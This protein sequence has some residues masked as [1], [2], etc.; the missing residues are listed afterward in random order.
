MRR[1][2]ICLCLGFAVIFAPI[3]SEAD[4]VTLP[5]K[6]VVLSSSGLAQIERE[7]SV[8]GN[9]EI[10]L[11]V[12]LDQVDDLLK[13]LA[14]FDGKGKVES[15]RLA[16]KEPLA[17]AFRSLPFTE[18]DLN[19]PEALLSA[20]RGTEVSIS[21]PRSIKGRIVSVTPFTEQLSDK[22][23]TT[24]HRLTVMGDDGLESTVLEETQQIEFTDHALQERLDK[25]LSAALDSRAKDQRV[26]AVNLVGQGSRPVSLAYVVSA[27]I[28]KTAYRLILPKNGAKA[29]LQGWAVLENMTGGDWDKVDLS[30]VSGNPVT[31]HQALY[32]S[33]YV[34]RP[35]IPVQVYG[36]VTPE[37]DKGE[38]EMSM[39]AAAPMPA[40]RAAMAN[41]PLEEMVVTAQRR[42]EKMAEGEQAVS[43]TET[44]AQV[45]FHFPQPVSVSAGQSLSVPFIGR[46]IPVERVWLYQP[47]VSPEHPLT[48]IRLTNDSDAGLPAGIVTVFEGEGAAFA[49][50]AQFP[51]LPRGDNRM[52]SFSLDQKT[53]I[54]S[55]ELSDETL[56]SLKADRGVVHVT[57]R[58]ISDTIYTIKAPADE[59]RTII[60]EHPKREDYAPDDPTGI[61]QTP[62]A[63]RIRVS[64]DAAKSKD[65][66]VRLA[67]PSVEDVRIA[68]VNGD[69]IDSWLEMAGKID[70]PAVLNALKEIAALQRAVSDAQAHVADLDSQ[71]ALIVK[72]QERL[73]AN[74][75]G[76]PNN[77]DLAKRYI[78]TL[79][80]QETELT[81]LAHKRAQAQQ[82]AK[83]AKDKLNEA[84]ANVKF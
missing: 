52:I 34:T 84:I 5:I 17:Q 71:T 28:W 61:E 10:S 24:R 2:P 32:E 46:D 66:H 72:D 30:I 62:T 6:R 39:A 23:T 7:G 50:D 21:G 65:V 48:A 44:G 59:G 58:E 77:S 45:A 75:A 15:V 47:A 35:D 4:T 9:A 79:S 16:G 3:A 20:L 49:G 70:N 81:D 12:P 27:P 83:A 18:G 74:L 73:R 63:Y 60:I 31:F 57:R 82:D 13:S 68:D 53:F 1:S 40:P 78:G 41:K 8:D 51:N 11:P 25:A 38:A 64:I 36:R 76:V 54:T 80:N 19:S 33:Y 22:A 14:I 55:R 69:M 67:A 26:L 37:S 42:R 29:T 56:F 43:S